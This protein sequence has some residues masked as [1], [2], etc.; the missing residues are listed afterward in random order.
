[1]NTEN[2]KTKGHKMVALFIVT[3]LTTYS[4]TRTADY[5]ACLKDY[6]VNKQYKC[7]KY[8]VID[9]KDEKFKNK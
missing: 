3:L 4:V 7:D 1:M 8:K 5:H 9:V 6:P 2:H